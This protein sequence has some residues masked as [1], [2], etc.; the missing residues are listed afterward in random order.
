MILTVPYYNVLCNFRMSRE[1]ESLDY[2][3]K[4]EI[5]NKCNEN[6]GKIIHPFSH[7]SIELEIFEDEKFEKKIESLNGEYE[8]GMPS[9]FVPYDCTSQAFDTSIRKMKPNEKAKITIISKCDKPNFFAEVR[10]LNTNH[11]IY[12]LNS[13]R[14]RPLEN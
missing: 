1:I 8:L 14:N 10:S 9:T 4:Y 3:L 11:L 5:I 2:L 6:A 7:V 13:R 12:V